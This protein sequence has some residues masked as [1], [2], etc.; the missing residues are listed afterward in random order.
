MEDTQIQ[1]Q[2]TP[3]QTEQ[4]KATDSIFS[5]SA[6]DQLNQMLNMRDEMLNRLLLQGEKLTEARQ[7]LTNNSFRMQI[8]TM[9]DL[10]DKKVE[11][12]IE[13]ANQRTELEVE[14]AK[15]TYQ[16]GTGF[17]QELIKEGIGV[18]KEN[19]NIILDTVDFI[20]QLRAKPVTE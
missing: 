19:P 7:E 13:L 10:Q 17:W 3:T 6:M 5:T 18:F 8:E 1:T 20:K 14:K 16:Q 11:T 9:K 12:L 2:V 15:I 4:A